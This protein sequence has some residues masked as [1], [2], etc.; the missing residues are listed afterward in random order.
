MQDYGPENVYAALHDLCL[1]MPQ[2]KY[3][4]RFCGFDKAAQLEGASEVSLGKFE[5]CEDGCS[6]MFYTQVGFDWRIRR[7]AVC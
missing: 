3:R 5:R 4:Y 2:D 6:R 7:C 1:E